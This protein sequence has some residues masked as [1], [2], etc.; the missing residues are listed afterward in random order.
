MDK[1]LDIGL[2]RCVLAF[3][4]G[5]PDSPRKLATFVRRFASSQAHGANVDAAMGALEAAARELSCELNW[6]AA[7]RALAWAERANHA[8]LTIFDP[9]YPHFLAEISHPPV[10]LFVIGDPEVLQQTQI[11]IV[12]SRKATHYGREAAFGIARGLA[13]AGLVVTSGMAAGI[14]AAAHRGA[15]AAERPTLAVFGCGIDRIYPRRHAELA[16]A[17]AADGALVSEFPLGTAPLPHH[18]PRRNRIISGLSVGTVVVEAALKSG[19]ITTA[20]HALEQS[21]D[22]FAVPGSVRNPLAAGCHAL[23][24]Q[25]AILVNDHADILEQYPEIS[26]LDAAAPA[27]DRRRSDAADVATEHER[28]VLDACA[29]DGASFDEIVRRSG[30]TAPEV[31]SILSALEVRGAVRSLAG[32]SYLRIAE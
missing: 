7:E 20:Q 25:G 1:G 32:N 30:L 18:F 14:D 21:R 6:A 23:I 13:R 24:Q 16:A 10:V 17:I 27:I 8:L 19:S 3:H 11:A 9:G 22:V 26:H 15:L 29:F 4:A 2:R 5:A 12:G 31:S 28:D